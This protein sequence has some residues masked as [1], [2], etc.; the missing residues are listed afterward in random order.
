MIERPQ[1]LKTVEDILRD[2]IEWF[3]N[4]NSKLAEENSKYHGKNVIV[5]PAGVGDMTYSIG[6][7]MVEW[8]PIKEVRVVQTATVTEAIFSLVRHDGTIEVYKLE[9]FGKT[10][11][12]VKVDADDALL[13]LKNNTGL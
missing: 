9:D 3:K 4:E 10:I 7:G 12:T 13:K 8:L 2:K 5:L 1:V 11:F 6:Y